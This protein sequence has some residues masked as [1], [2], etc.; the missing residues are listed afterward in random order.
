[1]KTGS[2]CQRVL[3]PPCTSFLADENG[4]HDT[5][6][7]ITINPLLDLADSIV[8]TSDKDHCKMSRDVGSLNT[9]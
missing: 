8:R 7:I 3:Q 4:P 1:M 9:T 2:R 6:L 5:F